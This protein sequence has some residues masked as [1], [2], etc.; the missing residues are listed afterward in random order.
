VE[1]D[2]RETAFTKIVLFLLWTILYTCIWVKDK[3]HD[4]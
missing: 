4:F 1:T 2:I 3:F